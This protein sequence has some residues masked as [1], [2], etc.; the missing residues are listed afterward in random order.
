MNGLSNI[1]NGSATTDDHTSLAARAG[2]LR[3]LQ[4]RQRDVLRKVVSYVWHLLQMVIAMEVGM[5]AY[6][7]LASTVLA[8]IGYAALTDAYPYVGYSAMVAG[9]VVGMVAFMLWQRSSWRHCLEMTLA[10]LAPVVVLAVLVVSGLV[11]IGVLYSLGDPLMI[12]AMALFM[13]VRPHQH[14]HGHAD[15]HTQSC[16]AEAETTTDAIAHLAARSMED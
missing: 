11:P 2:P 3:I 12:L 16:E 13:L 1:Q 7:L 4:P 14:A 10:M 6:H 8:R 15:G 9:M 5:F